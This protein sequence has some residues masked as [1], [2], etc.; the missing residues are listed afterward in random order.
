MNLRLT[1]RQVGKCRYHLALR[2][3]QGHSCFQED[4]RR[5]CVQGQKNYEGLCVV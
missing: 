1:V 3:T 5:L 2:K 4:E